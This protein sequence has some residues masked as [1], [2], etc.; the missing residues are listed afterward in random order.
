MVDLGPFTMVWIGILD[1]ETNVIV[2]AAWAG[3][4]QGYLREITV[5]A[6]ITRGSQGPHGAGR[7]VTQARRVQ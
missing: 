7:V 2:P 4:E 6:R 1:Q 3:N 5:A